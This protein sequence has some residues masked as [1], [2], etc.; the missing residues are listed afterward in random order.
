MAIERP[1]CQFTGAPPHAA[2]PAYLLVWSLSSGTQAKFSCAGHRFSFGGPGYWVSKV[3]GFEDNEGEHSTTGELMALP[4]LPVEGRLGDDSDER[5]ATCLDDECS[6]S[7]RLGEFCDECH[8]AWEK[9]QR[10]KAA[11]AAAEG[12]PYAI[13]KRRGF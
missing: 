3:E 5:L 6:N 9:K 10:A 7:A 12:C 1:R 2:S 13:N 4:D 11:A 8:G